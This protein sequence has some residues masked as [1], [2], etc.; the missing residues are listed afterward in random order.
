MPLDPDDK[1][2]RWATFGKQVEQFLESEIGDYLVKRAEA[3]IDDAVMRLKKAN[4]VDIDRVRSI[5]NEI[6]VAESVITWLGDAI[7]QGQAAIETLKGE[8]DVS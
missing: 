6:Q 7:A 3:E 1:L 4:P 8:D 2:V 5:Q